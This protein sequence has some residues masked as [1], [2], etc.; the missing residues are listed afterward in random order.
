MAPDQPHS[1]SRQSDKRGMKRPRR[2]RRFLG[3]TGRG[4]G[5]GATTLNTGARE[6]GGGVA[7]VFVGAF[8]GFAVS[9][10]GGDDDAKNAAMVSPAVVVPLNW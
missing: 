3:G 4:R 9:F 8:V 1:F 2:Q 6:C 7:G 5:A 10:G